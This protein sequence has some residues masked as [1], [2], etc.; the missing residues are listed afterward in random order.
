MT[1]YAYASAIMLSVTNNTIMLK[2]VVLSVVMLNYMLNVVTP[3]TCI[4]YL[5]ALSVC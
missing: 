2:V 3:F 5:S 1:I 4:K